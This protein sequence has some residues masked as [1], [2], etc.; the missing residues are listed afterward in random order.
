MNSL[1]ITMKIPSS[2]LY[3][4][5]HSMSERERSGFI[6][7]NSSNSRSPEYLKLFN[8]YSSQKKFDEEKIRS[9]L[10]L[11]SFER[12]KVYLH[13]N[14]LSYL[15]TL[16]T[17]GVEQEIMNMISVGNVLAERLLVN[18][19][20]A[21]FKKARKLALKK[22]YIHYVLM[23]DQKIHHHETGLLNQAHADHFRFKY[24]SEEFDPLI[25]QLELEL[26]SEIYLLNRRLFS[27]K[28]STLMRTKEAH[29]E[30]KNTFEKYVKKGE[31]PLM[32]F[33]A[34]IK[35]Y[36]V[37]AYYYQQLNEFDKAVYFFQKSVHAFENENPNPTENYNNYAVAYHNLM[38]TYSRVKNLEGVRTVL[39][40]LYVLKPRTKTHRMVIMQSCVTYESNYCK[41]VYNY[42]LRK[43][44]LA[45]TER[46]FLNNKSRIH[47][48]LYLQTCI[49][50][51]INYF[52]DKKFKK[53]LEILHNVSEY[54]SMEYY[55]DMVSV[56]KVYRLII[57]MEMGKMDL[58][59]FAIRNTYRHMLKHMQYFE[60]EKVVIETLKNIINI[61]SVKEQHKI[62]KQTAIK[63][64]ELKQNPDTAQVFLIFNFSGW[65]ACKV[66]NIDYHDLMNIE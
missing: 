9:R 41:Y 49:N 15:S 32:T 42:S 62:L 29:K 25:K 13:K 52:I 36:I 33:N 12:I 35:F 51:S 47:K 2:E 22:E 21:I 31:H 24:R 37:S 16:S 61:H 19:S 3:E 40:K 5:I 17:N 55:K 38:F 53:A 27:Q 54:E 46:Y 14:L 48:Q 6:E 57:Y 7:N 65:I 34:R 63:L 23:L 4:L 66:R 64:N 26:E 11:K 60:F 39:D 45:E 18:Q 59:S 1:K 44:R 30:L 58:L 28:N 50:L 8:A 10:H 20:L 56:M 43:K